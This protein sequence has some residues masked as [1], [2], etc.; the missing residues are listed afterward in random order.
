MPTEQEELKV[1][2]NLVDNAS[3]PL[4]CPPDPFGLAHFRSLFRK[5]G[6]PPSLGHVRPLVVA[7]VVGLHCDG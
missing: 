6:E 4:A 5:V 2:V 1:V 3:A 7:S